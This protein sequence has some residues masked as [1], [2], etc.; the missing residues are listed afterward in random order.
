MNV[1]IFLKYL[2]DYIIKISIIRTY[3]AVKAKG[4]TIFI[5]NGKEKKKCGES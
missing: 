5:T 3:N 1:L 4:K 2:F